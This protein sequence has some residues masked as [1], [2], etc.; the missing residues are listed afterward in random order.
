MKKARG[1]TLME[2]L[3]AVSV[4]ASGLFAAADLALTNVKLAD[5][6]AD[7]LTAVNFLREG[8][9]LARAHRDSNWLAGRA[10]TDGFAEG[11][12]YTAVPL[13][14][15]DA[16]T[17]EVTFV[18]TPDTVQNKGTVII[19]STTPETE[20]FYMQNGGIGDATIWSRLLTFHPICN[21]GGSFQYLDDGAT[22]GA[23][24]QVGIRVEVTVTWSRGSQSFSRTMYDDL[25]DWR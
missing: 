25:F 2:L 8:I 18:F 14:D 5:R 1:Q 12:D 10:F 3:V 21:Q 20:G 11:T 6:D 13:W 15:G 24:P 23:N 4:I 22:C 19:R 16:Q 9:E 17:S 7:A